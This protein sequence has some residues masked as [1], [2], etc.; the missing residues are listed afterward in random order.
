MNNTGEYLD[1]ISIGVLVACF[2]LNTRRVLKAIELCSECL[3][4]LKDKPGLNE[5]KLGKLFHKKIYLI[6]ANASRLSL[7]GDNANAKKY[8]EN[9]VEICSES[10]K[11]LDECQLCIQLAGI[12]FS[13]G[14]Y[15]KAKDLCEKALYVGK[16]ILGRNE[17]ALELCIT[18][19]ANMT[20]AEDISRNHSRSAKKLVTEL[21]KPPVMETWELCLNQLV[22]MRTA[23]NISRNH[24]RSTKKLVTELEKPAV[25]ETWDVCMNQLANTR[26]AENIS[27]NHL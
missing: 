26:K 19:L 23:E 2:L 22:N 13:Q 24:L 7:I 14:Q 8:A 20:K 16:D 3:L 10:G 18:Q 21:E 5:N 17:E 25:M 1:A 6:L 27:R 4:L 11:R 15:R 12:F 9:L